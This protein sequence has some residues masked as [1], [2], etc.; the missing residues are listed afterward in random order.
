MDELCGYLR[1][2]GWT[3]VELSKRLDVHVVTVNTWATGR[4]PVPKSVLLWLSLLVQVRRFGV[5]V[6][7]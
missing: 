2:L 7:R 5:E 4:I 1:E 6:G 3:Q